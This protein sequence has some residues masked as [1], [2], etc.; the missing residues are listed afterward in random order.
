MRNLD[1]IYREASAAKG[2]VKQARAHIL[3]LEGLALAIARE[4]KIAPE[5]I[6]TAINRR[7]AARSEPS[8]I[9]NEVRDQFLRSYRRMLLSDEAAA[10]DAA[11]AAEAEAA[12]TTPPPRKK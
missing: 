7:L 12:A 3:V 11:R 4:L 10:I 8:E 6:E 1:E 2:R 5:A 9:A